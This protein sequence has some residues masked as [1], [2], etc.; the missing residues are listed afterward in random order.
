MIVPVPGAAT[1]A[2]RSPRR[3]VSPTGK[4]PR[5]RESLSRSQ[6]RRVVLAAQGLGHRPERAVGI[7]DV[8]AVINRLAQFQIDSIN[9]VARAHYLPLF[10]RLGAYD[11]GL[12]DRAAGRAPR[13]LFEYWGHAASLIDVALQ[14]ALRSR[15]QSW[16]ESDMWGSMARIRREKPELIDWVLAELDRRGPTS[17]RQLDPQPDR[18]RDHW[19][20]NWSEVKTACEWLFFTG[21]I[22]AARRNSSFERLYDLPER[23]LPKNVWAEPTPDEPE[24]M[25]I[26][27]RRAA[28]ALGVASEPCLRD[29]FRTNAV[30]TRQAVA[31]LVESGELLPVRVQGWER[32]PTYLWHEATVPRRTRVRSLVSPFDSVMFERDRLEALFDFFYRIEIYVPAARRIHGYYV[33]PFLL[34]EDFV[35]RVDLKADRQAGVLRVNGAWAEPDRPHPVSEVAAELAAELTLMAGWLGL[36]EVRVVANGD[37]APALSAAFGAGSADQVEAGVHSR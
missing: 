4:V 20:W 6:A 24:T 21:A 3:P 34:G 32:Q 13:R 22:T 2:S 33:Y 8:Q 26:L 11:P 14:P 27:I 7:R 1:A 19:G 36:A 18:R 23:V 37:L 17:A 31:E 29:Y 28:R 12:L 15:M 16:A 30:R 5:P 35:A 9:I 10:S 25:R